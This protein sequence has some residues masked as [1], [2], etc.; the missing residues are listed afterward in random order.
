[1]PWSA[2]ARI[3]ENPKPRLKVGCAPCFSECAW[4]RVASMSITN[5]PGPAATGTSSHARC[6]AIALA[7]RSATRL[8]SASQAKVVI[9]RDTVGSEATCPNR[10]GWDRTTARSDRQSPPGRS[11]PQGPARSC[12]GHALL[13]PTST[14]RAAHSTPDPSRPQRPWRSAANHPPR[15]ATPRRQP[16]PEIVLCAGYASPTECLSARSC[17]VVANIRIPCRAGTSVLAAPVSPHHS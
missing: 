2:N 7:A 16:L 15:T 3:G 12:P 5:G 11:R 17:D 8:R 4:T 10:S 13:E 6:R 9:S 14:A 1:M